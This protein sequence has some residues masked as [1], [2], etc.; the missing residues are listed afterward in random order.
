MRP[1]NSHFFRHRNQASSWVGY[2]A[3]TGE[4]TLSLLSIASVTTA[5]DGQ[6]SEINGQARRDLRIGGGKSL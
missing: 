4:D 6:I 2:A 5:P 3:P 1:M